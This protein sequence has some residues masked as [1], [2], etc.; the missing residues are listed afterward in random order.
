MLSGRHSKWQKSLLAAFQ[1]PQM[2]SSEFTQKVRLILPHVL[3]CTGT[4]IYLCV[5]AKLFVLIE[6]P[7]EIEHR[8]FHVDNIRSLQ[9]QLI[10][11][12]IHQ[13]GNDS[14][15]AIIDQLIYI[16]M[17]AF[18]DGI[19]LDDFDTSQNTTQKWTFHS[20]CFFT[21]TVLTS[22]GYGN[23]IPISNFGRF[24]CMGY[25][26][27]GIPLTL[28]TIADV[29]KFLSDLVNHFYWKNYKK[30]TSKTNEGDNGSGSHDDIDDL[31]VTMEASG[32]AQIFVVLLLLTYIT[33]SAFVFTTIQDWN[34]LD[35]LYFS[36][37]T[38][39][40]VGFGDVVCNVEDGNYYG[41]IT[42]IFVGL[43]LTTL[44]VDLVGSSCIQNMHGFGRG[45]DALGFLKSALRNQKPGPNQT[46]DAYCP[47]EYM[48]WIDEIRKLS[49]LSYGKGTNE[50]GSKKSSQSFKI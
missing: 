19:T 31:A 13:N 9:K 26:V 43:I 34:F 15:N 38:L 39:L 20:A 35:S 4:V 42:F 6:A 2:S 17:E 30:M 21:V 45:F 12:D 8:K 44:T 23:L 28:I 49:S 47:E 40:T 18:S 37:I 50:N 22:I 25:A 48:P 29:A 7:Y 32:S 11:F 36:V 14:A 1:P 46:W 3:L 27:L 10:Q 41:W 33:L 5:G 24:F 16:S